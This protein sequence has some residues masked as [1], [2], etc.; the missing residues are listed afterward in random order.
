MK[1]DVNFPVRIS[2]DAVENEFLAEI[3]AF[4][5]CIAYG[6]TEAAALKELRIAK[7]LW[8]EARRAAGLPVPVPE[9]TIEQLRAMR[10]I[11]NISKIARIA[12]V[13][14][15]TLISKVKRGSP[16]TE[17]EGKR[18]GSVLARFAAA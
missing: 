12:G 14:E 2:W 7:S 11:L 9:K 4:E 6:K 16:L 13:H 15:Q 1:N 8:L 5:G 10:P 3:P 18:I 17:S